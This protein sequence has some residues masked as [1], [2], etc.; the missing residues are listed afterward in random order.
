MKSP[1]KLS[2][3]KSNGEI[4][5]SSEDEMLPSSSSPFSTPNSQPIS[6]VSTTNSLHSLLNE[7]T[8]L[9][10][11]PIALPPALQA[12]KF[13]FNA[14]SKS[15]SPIIN[16]N[17]FDKTD[18]LDDKINVIYLNMAE[19]LLRK[20]HPNQYYLVEFIGSKTDNSLLIDENRLIQVLPDLTDSTVDLSKM[21]TSFSQHL[22]GAKI[23]RTTAFNIFGNNAF[24]GDLQLK[25]EDFNPIEKTDI[26]IAKEARISLIE[27]LEYGTF[28]A[29]EIKEILKTFFKNDRIFHQND[30][31]YIKT[32]LHGH[33]ITVYFEISSPLKT[34][35]YYDFDSD[36]DE[37]IPYFIVNSTTSIYQQPKIKRLFPKNSFNKNTEFITTDMIKLTDKIARILKS[38][39]Y[40]NEEKTVSSTSSITSILAG[41]GGCGI[42]KVIKL[43]ADKLCVDLIK[44]DCMDFWNIEG[45]SVEKLVENTVEKCKSN[46]KFKV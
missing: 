11:N 6:R 2:M 10:S 33:T 37:T 41:S 40:Q 5:E 15:L 25:V 36:S 24:M 12:F 32:E 28:D 39:F 26:K 44:I 19:I 14:F 35:T 31:F 16:L 8:L 42:N 3:R 27:N 13:Y 45:K 21:F 7:D 20:L 17:I 18:K 1:R 34:E 9:A 29:N 43:L 46:V 23:S 38:Q 22:N 30:V 4:V